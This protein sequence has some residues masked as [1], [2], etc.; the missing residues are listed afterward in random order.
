[1]LIFILA[2]AAGALAM[3]SLGTKPAESQQTS[4][5]PLYEVHDL[6]TLPGG[7]SSAATGI[8][9]ANQV[10]GN[11]TTSSDCCAYHAF[12]YSDGQMRDLGTLEGGSYSTAGGINNAGQVVG[13]STT[14]GEATMHA[15]LYSDGQMRDLGTLEGESYSAASGIN[16]AGKVVGELGTSGN[17]CCHAFLYSEGVLKDLGTLGGANSSA[18]G[19]NNADQVVGY[20]F[21]SGDAEAHAFLWDTTNR[22][23]DLGTLGGSSSTASD[24]NNAGDVVGESLTS[25]DAERHAFLY[26]GGVMK[27]LGTLEGSSGWSV[28]FGIN[29]AGDVVGSSDTSRD[30]DLPF[31]YSDGVMRDLNSLIPADSGWKLLRAQAINNNGYIVGQGINKDGQEHAFLL[32]PIPYFDGFYQPVDNLP[33]LNKTK[34]GKTIPIRF[35]LGGDKGLDIFA[36][37]YPKSEPIS[38][39]SAATVD[40]IEVT[41][42][43]KGALS[44]NE[45]TD[46]YEYEWA[47]SSSWS[48]CRQFVMRLKDGTVQRANFIFR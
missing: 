15:F 30:A 8:N 36:E 35:S 44:Y 22:M 14:S 34:P 3:L 19:I 16:D 31:I 40:G 25:G 11:A 12:L 4:E 38:C 13:R 32:K 17:V 28:A 21:T 39:D 20:S 9:D 43:G 45:S 10:V 29:D 33:T 46:T 42:S 37:G 27:D 47:T 7:S 18:T 5:P 23:T 1:M 2:L 6:G 26:R 24:I 48:G 41:L